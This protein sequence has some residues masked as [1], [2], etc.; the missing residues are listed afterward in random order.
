MNVTVPTTT[1][2]VLDRK[3]LVWPSRLAVGAM[4]LGLLP[5]ELRATFATLRSHL[6]AGLDDVE[7]ATELG[8]SLEDLEELKRRFYAHEIEIER[9]K[10]TDRHYLDYLIAQRGN[11]SDLQKIITKF[12][13]SKQY[14]ALVGAIRA[15]SEI[16]EKVLERGRD[17][18]VIDLK[19]APIRINGLLVT[20]LPTNAIR[21][22]IADALHELKQLTAG[23]NMSSMADVELPQIH[24]D[25][26]VIDV[27]AEPVVP[28]SISRAKPKKAVRR[29]RP[30]VQDDDEAPL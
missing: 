11:I 14:N 24:G 10:S 6:S 5:S 13:E 23:D 9:K 30:A 1:N 3:T 22:T 19:S 4:F 18:G 21:A 16:I 26:V 28:I 20:E 7:I 2:G 15:K 25:D 27:V 12:G 29:A 17:F 8:I